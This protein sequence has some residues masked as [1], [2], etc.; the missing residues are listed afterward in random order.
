[1]LKCRNVSLESDVAKWLLLII[2]LEIDIGNKNIG[3]H[4]NTWH[5]VF[6]QNS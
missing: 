5:D 6:M 1:M 4:I 2:K 3:Y